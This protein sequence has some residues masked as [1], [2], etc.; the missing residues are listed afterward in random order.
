MPTYTFDMHLKAA[1]TVNG[2]TADEALAML[3]KAM[4]SA[5]CNGGSWPSGE[6]ILF[7]AS[8]DQR[9]SIGLIDGE[10]A[11]IVTLHDW[12]ELRVREAAT[13][14]KAS[15]LQRAGFVVG[16]RD[17]NLNRRFPGA[18][19]VAEPYPEGTISDDAGNGPW[20]IVGDNLAEL[21]AEAYADRIG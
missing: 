7:E 12:Q 21:V 1:V 5:N 3:E 15:A 17:H 14:D 20:C 19:M 6:P 18:F 13:S 16:G 10:D 9:P 4:D 8:L 2:S 11:S